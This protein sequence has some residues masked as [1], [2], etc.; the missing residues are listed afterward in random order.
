MIN[1]KLTNEFKLLIS[2]ANLIDTGALLRSVKV[3]VNVVGSKITINI[4]ANDYVK[5]HNERYDLVKNF[6]NS[7]L[8][9][10]EIEVILQGLIDA[11]FEN[12]INGTSTQFDPKVFILLNGK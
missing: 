12:I 5:Y 11:K 8:L 2:G 4:I 9:S 7:T 1:T 6:S 10:K 3:D